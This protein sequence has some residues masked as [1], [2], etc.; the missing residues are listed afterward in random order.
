MT[1]ADVIS[2]WR[3]DAGTEAVKVAS[4]YQYGVACDTDLCERLRKIWALQLVRDNPSCTN[5]T[6]VEDWL[7]PGF[8]TPVTPIDNTDSDV[9]SL[10]FTDITTSSACDTGL[11]FSDINPLT[12]S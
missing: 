12:G 11:T 3:C 10:S 8:I 6:K 5:S 2:R 9:C 7:M 1:I 4:N